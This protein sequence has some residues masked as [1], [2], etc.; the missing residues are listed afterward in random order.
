MLDFEPDRVEIQR[1]LA[2]MRD[3]AS[4]GMQRMSGPAAG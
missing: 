2:A 3:A 4:R 1:Q